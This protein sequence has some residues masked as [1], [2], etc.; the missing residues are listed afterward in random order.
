[1]AL[2]RNE[3]K[4]PIVENKTDIFKEEK[5]RKRE[6]ENVVAAPFVFST[7]IHKSESTFIN[8]TQTKSWFLLRIENTQNE[9]RIV[10]RKKILLQNAFLVSQLRLTV[11]WF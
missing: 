3:I 11:F 6:R 9:Q 4:N 5:K 1:M 2:Q 8:A 7:I 10:E